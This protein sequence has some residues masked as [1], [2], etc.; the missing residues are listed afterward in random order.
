MMM[1][2]VSFLL[3]N[4]LIKLGPSLSIHLEY[5]LFHGAFLDSTKLVPWLISLIPIASLILQG[6]STFSFI[7]LVFFYMPCPSN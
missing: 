6:L 2:R 4:L 7:S 5:H 1:V 3:P